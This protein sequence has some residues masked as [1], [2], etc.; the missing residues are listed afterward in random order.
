ML[1][2]KLFGKEL[3]FKGIQEKGIRW[4]LCY[5]EKDDLVDKAAAVAPLDFV[6]AEVTV[7]PRA[8][9]PS[10]HRGPIRR[11]SAPCI[12]GSALTGAPFA[13]SS[14]WRKRARSDEGTK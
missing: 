6:N 5:A 8:M 7:F 10:P 2:V 1:P 13:F 9:A 4:F 12:N 14:T 11:R 3:N